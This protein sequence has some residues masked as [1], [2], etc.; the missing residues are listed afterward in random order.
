[1]HGAYLKAEQYTWRA[2]TQSVRSVQAHEH[3]HELYRA[4]PRW[5]LQWEHRGPAILAEIEHWAPDI[6]CLQEVDRP[7]EFHTSLQNLGWASPLS[8]MFFNIYTHSC[9]T[10]LTLPKCLD[11]T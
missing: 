8:M 9:L 4:V 11:N 6:G 2:L 7:D 5:C 3:A 1:M 10:L